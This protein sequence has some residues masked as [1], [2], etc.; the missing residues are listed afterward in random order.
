[1]NE[2]SLE[3]RRLELV[4]RSAAQRAALIAEL[5]PLVTRA[6]AA[7][8]IVLKVRSHPVVTALAV[9]GLAL[10]GARRIFSLAT[11]VMSLYALF[12]R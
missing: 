11:Q 3:A 8:R 1:M 7:D 10:L 2:Q 6:A 12:R 4:Q 9:G 5:E